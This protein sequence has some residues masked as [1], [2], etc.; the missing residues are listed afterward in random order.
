[1]PSPM[2]AN[3]EINDE[4][5]ERPPP[6]IEW[7]I[8]WSSNLLQVGMRLWRLGTDDLQARGFVDAGVVRRAAE[9]AAQHD[10]H[11][12]RI[13]PCGYKGGDGSGAN[14]RRRRELIGLVLFG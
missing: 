9:P 1:M 4:K 7:K 10:I 2:N 14:S 11:N 13:V 6:P 5:L 12:L 3:G 8:S